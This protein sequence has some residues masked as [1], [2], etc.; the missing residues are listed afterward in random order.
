M[1]HGKRLLIGT[2]FLIIFLVNMTAPASAY[3]VKGFYWHSGHATMHKDSSIPSTWATSFNNAANAWTNAG[4]IFYY[5]WA[6]AS[7]NILYY[8]P[9]S[10]NSILAT[11]HYDAT[12]D[13]YNSFYI[14]FN[15]NKAWS[16]ASN[17]ESGKFDVESVAAHEF[18]HGLGL[19]H[20]IA[21]YATMFE[22]TAAGE[23]S[24]RSLHK[25]DID[26][27]KSIYRGL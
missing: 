22:S 5:S 3:S 4:T 14:E 8:T 25:D 27:I 19:G 6:A 12:G 13:V 1:K 23:I 24:K 26:G 2:L 20:S 18:G 7:D 16:T 21:L 11:T 10:N 17:G 15:S 9:L